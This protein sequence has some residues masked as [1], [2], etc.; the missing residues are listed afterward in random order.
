M[1]ELSKCDGAG[2]PAP[3][4]GRTCA[5]STTTWR[6]GGGR[7]ARPARSC[8]SRCRRARQ[9]DHATCRARAALSILTNGPDSFA[10]RK[11]GVLVTDGV[12]GDAARARLKAAAGAGK[13]QRWSW[14]PPKVGGVDDATARTGAGR[15]EDRRRPVGA[16]TTRWRSCSLR[17]RRAC[18][19]RPRRR[20]AT[21]SPTPSP[22]ASS[23]A[24]PATPA[25]CSRR[26]ASPACRRRLRQP[27]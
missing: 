1:F 10:G 26:P 27:G 12:D 25:R 8:P 22:T 9:A 21:S 5:T 16:R 11:V 7:R 24:T 4:G 15:P 20:R 18:A 19:R 17:A 3:D 6:P 23:S 13:V 2:D 14:S